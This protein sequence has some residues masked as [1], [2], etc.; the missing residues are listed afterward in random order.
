MSWEVSRLPLTVEVRVRTRAK[1]CETCGDSVAMREVCPR[2]SVLSCQYCSTGDPHLAE[3]IY[4]R[5]TRQQ[6]SI[7]VTPY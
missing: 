7:N 1:P 4:T 5:L 3:Y 2:V 6:A